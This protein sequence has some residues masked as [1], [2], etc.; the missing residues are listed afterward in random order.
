MAF[1]YVL[2]DPRTE[3]IRY[4]GWTSTT[5]KRRLQAHLC[6]RS[7]VH[8]TRWI[9]SLL[10]EGL[11]PCIRAVQQVPLGSWGDAERYWIAYFK[12]IGC[13]LTNGTEGGEGSLGHQVNIEARQR[14]SA[15]HKGKKI[16]PAQ[17]RAVGEAASERWRRWRA[18]GA[19]MPQDVRDKIG[20]ANKGKKHSEAVKSKLAVARKGLTK[21]AEHREK[22]RQTLLVRKQ[23]PEHKAKTLMNAA[24]ASKARWRKDGVFGVECTT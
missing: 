12:K 13:P 18:S 3:E 16:S 20:A 22:I 2:I 11:R 24:K 15:C 21:S 17:R 23:S 8:R 10:R 1:I 5:L 7:G 6:S 4:V 19:K 9:Q 14:I